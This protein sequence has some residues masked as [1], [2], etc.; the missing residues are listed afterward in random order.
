MKAAFRVYDSYEHAL[1]DYAKLLT[2]NPRYRGGAV[3]FTG[4]GGERCRRGLCDRPG[5]RQKLITI[6]QKVKGDIQQG[7]N[8]YKMISTKFLVNFKSP[9]K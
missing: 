6:I 8:A 4:A 7:V 3:R 1:A 2:N 5:L 9:M